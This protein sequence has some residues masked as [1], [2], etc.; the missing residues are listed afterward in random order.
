MRGEGA[1]IEAQ[2]VLNRFDEGTGEGGTITLGGVTLSLGGGERT[3]GYRYR[4]NILALDRP[5]YVL[6]VV[7]ADGQTGAPTEGGAEKRFLITYRSEEHLEK[8][9]KR[10]ALVV[11]WAA[12]GLFPLG[13]IFLAI[14]VV[15]AVSAI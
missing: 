11:G 9:Y 5:V 6:G 8:K 10:D 1:E 7:Q 2:E 14:G 3:L 12:L 15:E 4:E 13:A